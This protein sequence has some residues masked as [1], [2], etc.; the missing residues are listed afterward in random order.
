MASNTDIKFKASRG[1]DL[2]EQPI[3]NAKDIYPINSNGTITIHGNFTVTQGFSVP[4]D[5]D[6]I[7]DSDDTSEVGQSALRWGNG[8]FGQIE[9]GILYVHNTASSNAT[10]SVGTPLIP[11]TN[12]DSLGNTSHVWTVYADDILATGNLTI[13][14]VNASGN[15]HI[16]GIINS[17]ANITTSSISANGKLTIANSEPKIFL[18]ESDV[19]DNNYRISVA[20]GQ[21]KLDRVDNSDANPNNVMYVENDG[22]VVFASDVTVSGNLT[23]SGNTLTIDAQGLEIEDAILYL[24]TGQAAN[25]APSPTLEAGFEIDRGTSSNVSIL[26]KESDDTWNLTGDYSIVRQTNTV[27]GHVL[28]TTN[29]HATYNDAVVVTG[30]TSLQDT[31]TS[32]NLYFT[33]ET[34]TAIEWTRGSSNNVAIM[35][36]ETTDT[37]QF[38]YANGTLDKIATVNADARLYTVE[39]VA[40][41][42]NIRLSDNFDANTDITLQAGNNVSIE[43]T[44][45][46]ELTINSTNQYR[47]YTLSNFKPV[48]SATVLSLSAVDEGGNSVGASSTL[49]FTNSGSVGIT[50]NATHISFSGTDTN[51]IYDLAT[52]GSN[53][54]QANIVLTAS[55]S[56][57]GADVIQVVGDGYTTVSSNATHIIVNSSQGIDDVLT[58][59]NYTTT[60]DLT[61]RNF[62]ALGNTDLGNATSDRISMIGYVDTNITPYS[63]NSYDLGSASRVWRNIYTG[64]LNMSNMDGDPNEVDGTRGSWSIQ[65]GEDDLFL[66]NKRNGK[67]YKFKLEEVK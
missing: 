40:N 19:T 47:V 4:A 37:L 61:V 45:N 15:V 41:T 50:S 48:P 42:T 34:N 3:I 25:A 2:A 26:W 57:T 39:V 32:G 56:G 20:S 22:S 21:F 35:W 49:S 11:L 7:P 58:V 53:T 12:G 51:H 17:S 52:A 10:G 9:A 1:I 36:N 55:G 62:T 38:K 63:N 18:K 44:A 14:T 6:F 30:N 23:V 16:G 60:K 28:V 54:V 31:Y 67:K 59:D 66:I 13:A 24:N 8:Y 33:A 46:N 43:N 29:N 64:D 65:E 27:S 5:G